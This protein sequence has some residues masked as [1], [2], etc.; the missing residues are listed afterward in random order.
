M[1]TLL[2]RPNIL[3]M[4]FIRLIGFEQKKLEIFLKIAQI[5][6]SFI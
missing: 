3:Q 2:T 1:A 4:K 6:L 5:R